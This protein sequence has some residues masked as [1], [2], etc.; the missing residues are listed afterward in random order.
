MMLTLMLFD[1][2]RHLFFTFTQNLNLRLPHFHVI[3]SKSEIFYPLI[4]NEWPIIVK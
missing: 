2:A 1:S 3:A 4:N